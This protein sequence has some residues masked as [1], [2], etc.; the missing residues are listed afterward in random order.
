VTT[1][2]CGARN[3]VLIGHRG[4]GKTTVARLLGGRLDWPVV[5]T[6]RVIE[7]ATGKTI[8]HIIE[9]DGE[10]RFRDLETQQV[11]AAV[12]GRQQVISVG[13]GA[14]E[15]QE[16]RRM[17]ALAGVTLWLTAP[18]DELLRRV[19]A[20]PRSAS[21]R[22]ALTNRGTRREVE[23]LLAR[24]APLYAALANHVLDTTGRGVEAVADEAL[25]RLH[26]P[27]PDAE[28]RNGRPDR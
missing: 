4:C 24:R 17:L 23:Y 20:D 10:P 2:G 12:R 1:T 7:Q 9:E 8:K 21:T 26:F 5:D 22:P 25:Q 19:Q 16:N 14:I 11:E 15:R 3:I 18:A 6:D 13:G 27:G 28:R